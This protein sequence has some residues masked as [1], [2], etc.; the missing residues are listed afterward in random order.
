[1]ACAL[2][3]ENGSVCLTKARLSV[4]WEI[5][6]D[7]V[8]MTIC[9]HCKKPKCIEDCPCDAIALNEDRLVLID[10]SKCV[11]CGNCARNCPFDAVVFIEER[12]VYQK[13][14]MCFN[15][16]NGP[17]CVEVCPVGALTVVESKGDR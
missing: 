3:H 15:R 1:M 11:A 13:C 9:R 12:N 7:K 17:V 14:D 10:E 4:S 6:D 2:T 8:N 5:S 16:P